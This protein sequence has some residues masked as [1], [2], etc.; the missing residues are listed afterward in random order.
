MTSRA[1]TEQRKFLWRACGM[2]K[3]AQEQEFANM[4]QPTSEEIQGLVAFRND[5]RRSEWF[6]HLSA[7]S[8]SIPALAWVTQVLDF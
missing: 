8:E 7:V 2:Q 6:N 4:L 3:P 1:F 5:N